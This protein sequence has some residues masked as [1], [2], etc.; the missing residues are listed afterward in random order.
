MNDPI[1]KPLELTEGAVHEPSA[2]PAAPKRKGRKKREAS[3]SIRIAHMEY[4]YS[5][6]DPRFALDTI[7]KLMRSVLGLPAPEEPKP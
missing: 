7:G 4:S 1:R 2:V 5:G 6:D 3:V